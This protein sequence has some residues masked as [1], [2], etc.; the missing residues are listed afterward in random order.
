MRNLEGLV[1]KRIHQIAIWGNT[2]KYSF[3]L[4][5]NI[6]ECKH[7]L[8]NRIHWLQVVAW[9]LL[10]LT[11][12]K[13]MFSMKWTNWKQIRTKLIVLKLHLNRG[14]WVKT[15]DQ[16]KWISIKMIRILKGIQWCRLSLL[17]QDISY[18]AL[19]QL[20]EIVKILKDTTQSK[21]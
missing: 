18:P 6:K 14:F 8:N 19:V 13:Q 10:E 12:T 9:N 21:F 16:W 15:L 17:V 2:R 5:S 1:K 4:A 20:K 7:K 11:N 3:Q